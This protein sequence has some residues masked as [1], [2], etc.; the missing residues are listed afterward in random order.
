MTLQDI[1]N[2]KQSLIKINSIKFSDFKIALKL[3]SFAKKIDGYLETFQ[4]EQKKV[5][6]LYAKKD[7][8]NQPIIDKNGQIEFKTAEDKINFINDM[9]DI[10]STELED[11]KPITIKV[12]QVQT[13]TEI[14]ANDLLA[15]SALI[16][17]EEE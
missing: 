6:E 5:I 4:S 8:N 17:W 7:E 10:L 3:A 12:S 14:S 1:L 11:L 16:N 13:A 15:V 2:S 9:N